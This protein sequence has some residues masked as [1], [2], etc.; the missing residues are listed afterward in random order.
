VLSNSS[1]DT[2]SNRLGYEINRSWQVYGSLG[3]EKLR[4][5]GTPATRIDD[6]TWGIGAIYT[7]NPDSQITFGYGHTAGQNGLQFSGYYALS[8][9]TR[10]TARYSTGLE[11][12]LQQL[13]G[14]LDLAALDQ[15]GSAVDAETGA[16]LF[17]AYSGLGVQGGVYRAKTLSVTATT[18]LDRDE[19]NFSL[20]WSQRTAVSNSSSVPTSLNPV[21]QS[22]G[23]KSEGFTGIATW[24]HQLSE[25]LSMSSTA[26]YGVSDFDNVPA[27]QG[28]GRQ[29]SIGVSV[30]MQYLISPTLAASMRYSYF[31]RGSGVPGQDIYQNLFLV[32]LNKTF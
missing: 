4:Y 18:T 22:V 27:S 2:I 29:T 32:S 5:S 20:Q 10:I 13:Q 31:E 3:Y 17:G 26:S 9:R 6:M 30:G 21:V 7:P 25:V 28:G 1:E 16:P 15:N 24:T 14:Q 8:A 12:D 23:S 19:I 11:T